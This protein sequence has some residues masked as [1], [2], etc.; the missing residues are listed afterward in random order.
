[1][2]APLG[3]PRETAFHVVVPVWR[4][5]CWNH[6]RAGLCANTVSGVLTKP[7]AAAAG[8][9]RPQD[10]ERVAVLDIG[11]CAY[12]GESHP[13]PQ[14]ELLRK[15]RDACNTYYTWVFSLAYP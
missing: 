14:F 8:V 11:Q 7:A 4:R 6:T 9:P 12:V 1:M 5:L 3:L 10:L 13:R 2:Q 15:V